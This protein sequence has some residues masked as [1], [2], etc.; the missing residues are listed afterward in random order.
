MSFSIFVLFNSATGPCQS[1]SKGCEKGDHED[2]A[3]YTEIS[4]YCSASPWQD[5]HEYDALGGAANERLLARML[6]LV[7]ICLITSRIA[8]FFKT[9]HRPRTISFQSIRA[10]LLTI[11]S[12]I[13]WSCVGIFVGP[14]YKRGTLVCVHMHRQRG[15]YALTFAKMYTTV[16]ICIL[17]GV[18]LE[19]GLFSNQEDLSRRDARKLLRSIEALPMVVCSPMF[20]KCFFTLLHLLAFSVSC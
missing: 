14:S 1:G 3:G 9:W 16:S 20:C 15:R 11:C 12:G 18:C 7:V 8:V 10:S 17:I 4:C 2:R 6:P 5:A 13:R 19:Y